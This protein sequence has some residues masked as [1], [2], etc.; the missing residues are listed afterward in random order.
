MKLTETEMG[1][2]KYTSPAYSIGKRAILAVL[3]VVS[4]AIPIALIMRFLQLYV[5]SNLNV[6]TIV[7]AIVW[8][9]FIVGIEYLLVGIIVWRFVSPR[10]EIFENGMTRFVIPVFTNRK[11]DYVAFSDMKSFSV[12]EDGH[13][14][15]VRVR[16]SGIPLVWMAFDTGAVGRVVDKLRSEGIREIE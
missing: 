7:G 10:L 5:P 9:L 16:D 8:V 15:Y 4:I 12:S 14:C 3:Y 6:Y 11:G 2:L 13:K 1:S